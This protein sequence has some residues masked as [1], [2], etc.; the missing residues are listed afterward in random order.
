MALRSPHDG[1]TRTWWTVNGTSDLVYTHYLA[2][3]NSKHNILT[4]MIKGSFA[5]KG[6]GV[7]SKNS[8][9]R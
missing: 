4:N 7:T 5:S 2:R 6:A 3:Y 9:V 8:A 1:T